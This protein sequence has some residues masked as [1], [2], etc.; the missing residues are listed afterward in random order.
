M[1]LSEDMPPK[2]TRRK[3]DGALGLQFAFQ[4]ESTGDWHWLFFTFDDLGSL[5]RHIQLSAQY[6]EQD[7]R[8]FW[9][10]VP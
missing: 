1:K 7:P 3:R 5:V 9:N 2:P 10:E 8:A 4:D 6:D